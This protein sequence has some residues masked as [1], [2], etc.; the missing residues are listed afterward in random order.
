[1]EVA[2]RGIPVVTPHEHTEA[3]V[4]TKKEAERKRKAANKPRKTLKDLPVRDKLAE[5]LK[6]GPEV[7][8]PQLDPADRRRPF[9]DP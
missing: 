5:Q 4:A 3:D 2:I 6:G 8:D 1:M 9:Y 7:S